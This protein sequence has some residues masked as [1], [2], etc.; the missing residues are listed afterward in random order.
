MAEAG[1]FEQILDHSHRADPYPLY[2][3][4]RKTPVARQPDG[5]YVVSTYRHIAALMHDPRLSSDLRPQEERAAAGQK[6]SMLR[7]DPPDHD[8]VRRLTM[9]HFGPPHTPARVDG[10]YD[11]LAE[12]VSRLV[13]DFSG[14][15]QVDVV[16]DFAYPFPVAEIC[17][18]LG[19]PREDEPRF[20]RW[21]DVLVE[22]TDPKGDL[23]DADPAKIQAI[24][25]FQQYLAGL[26]ATHRQ[27]PGDDLLSALATDDGPEGRLGDDELLGQA[28]LLLIAG[29][30]TTVNLIAHGVLT[31]LRRPDVLQRLREDP[32]LSIRLVEE[33]LRYEPS[34]QMIPW[35]KAIAD[36]ELGDTTIPGGSLVTLVLAAGD[37][38][39]DQFRD[40]DRFDP[41]RQ[42]EHLSFGGG[43]HFCFGAPLARLETQLALTEFARRVEN[44][45][46]VVDPPPYRPSP[47]LRGPLHLP[48]LLDGVA[49][50][51]TAASRPAPEMIRQRTPA[52]QDVHARR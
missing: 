41:D 14:K 24:V 26:V 35:R 32:D 36:I 17:K 31:L 45:R 50:A 18:L 25:D 34:V 43:T 7:L 30:E 8:R 15:H 33:L 49:P 39:P 6:P 5:T 48:V 12:T 46:L 40:P 37:R 23:K 42:S 3:E 1:V 13:D 27:Q 38:D 4:L 44:P 51:S 11:E 21:V 2:A 52:E 28:M 16:D 20:S 22:T 9:R 29:H 19:V 47:V 10:M